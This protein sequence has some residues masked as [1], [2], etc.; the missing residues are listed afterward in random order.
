MRKFLLSNHKIA[1]V[2]FGKKERN[3]FDNN[4]D[5]DNVIAHHSYPI[6]EDASVPI[7]ISNSDKTIVNAI[8]NTTGLIVIKE[9]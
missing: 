2:T 1:V 3:E 4:G 9:L 6:Q 5:K 7:I 8:E